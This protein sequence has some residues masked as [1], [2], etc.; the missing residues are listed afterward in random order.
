MWSPPKPWEIPSNNFRN[1]PST[2]TGASYRPS[3][4]VRQ[5]KPTIM[6]EDDKKA[7]PTVP[8]RPATRPTQSLYP[9][10]GHGT[11]GNYSNFGG[12]M[13]PYSGGYT[14]GY[15]GYG[16]YNGY[17]NMYGGYG[18]NRYSQG[19]NN[20]PSSSFVEQAEQNS[21]IAF[22]S[23]H[24][25]V[26]A[27][28]SIAMML[29]STF[30]AVHSSFRAVLGVADHFSRLRENLVHIVGSNFLI[31]WLRSIFRKITV[32]IGLSSSASVEEVWNEMRS[33]TRETAATQG[34]QSRVWK[35]WPLLLF[36]AVVLGTPWLIWRFLSSLGDEDIHNWMK[37]E[38]D[39]VLGEV[40]Y[41]FIA[42]AED[43]LSI[44]AGKYIKI[45]PKQRQPRIRG[46]LLATVN[47]KSKGIVPAN[48]VKILGF[49]RGRKANGGTEQ[50][51]NASTSGEQECD[52]EEIVDL[53][54]VY[55]RTV[56]NDFETQQFDEVPRE[57]SRDPSSDSELTEPTRN[58]TTSRT[59]Q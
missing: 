26:Q 11:Y 3:R 43:E 8:P 36:F 58:P 17:N 44:K 19:Y 37:G 9:S 40:L 32:L 53:D 15:G 59:I 35:S 54:D 47:G 23:V 1:L 45:A 51:L 41:D 33:M 25:I 49:K 34:G 24:S 55:T 14:N 20:A 46:W 38:G 16:G 56:I 27:F 13:G 48:Y 22:D 5:V 7:A 29:E 2:S 28:G 21:R 42:E 12:Y 52:N 50:K 57:I 31:K 6:A 4:G 39:H 10:Y 30:F 18:A